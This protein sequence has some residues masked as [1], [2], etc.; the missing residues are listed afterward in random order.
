MT[1]GFMTIPGGLRILKSMNRLDWSINVDVSLTKTV[2]TV[3]YILLNHFRSSCGE[4]QW[5]GNCILL[6]LQYHL[7]KWMGQNTWI[8]AIT[9]SGLLKDVRTYVSYYIAGPHLI[10]SSHILRC[11]DPY[12]YIGH[13]SNIGWAWQTCATW[14]LPKGENQEDTFV[15]EIL[16][17]LKL[18]KA[19]PLTSTGIGLKLT[20]C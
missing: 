18:R 12:W 13:K 11:I 10:C 5:G 6:C 8:V 9:F 20:G 7:R 19:W 4:R 2:L 1:Y 17:S 15:S 3:F 14:S 16:V